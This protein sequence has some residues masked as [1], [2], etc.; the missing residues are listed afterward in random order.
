M[1]D[2]TPIVVASRSFSNNPVL[3]KELLDLY[4][5][6]RFN[7]KGVT[8]SGAALVSFL[9]GAVKAITGLEVLDDA[10]FA[11]LP[12]LKVISKYGVGLDMIDLKA[13]ERRGVLLGWTGGVNKR[14]VS[15]LVLSCIIA[16]LHRVPEASADMKTGKWKPLKGLQLT[17]KTVGIVGCGQVGKD[18]A[19]L[20]G[21]FGCRVLSHDISSFPDFYAEN[22]ITLSSLDDLLKGSDIVTL[23]LPL[24]SLT[25]N[26]IS[27]EKLELM[28]HGAYLINAARGGLVDEIKLKDMLK[29][30]RLAG[31]F[32]DV[33]AVEPLVDR[34]LANLPNVLLTPHIGGSTE[35][36]QLAMGR[37]AIKG[38]DCAAQVNKLVPDYLSVK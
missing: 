3:K 27:S 26:I 2:N 34:E 31:A 8:Y 38:L 14:S 7:E 29:N 9:Q 33:F 13:M 30:G 15:E 19:V 23:H 28:K 1:K 16:L 18:L 37:A 10:V 25:R 12:D 24:N 11:A 36:A 6:A 22:H 20:L 32:L 17:G 21:A 35:E 4:P 5:N